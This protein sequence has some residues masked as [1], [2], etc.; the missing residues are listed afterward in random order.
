[1]KKTIKIYLFA[2]LSI[3]MSAI[4]CKDQ[5]LED[6]RSS[7]ITKQYFKTEGDAQAA[8]AGIY[9]YIKQ[10]FNKLGYD[11]VPY[12]MLELVT[13]IYDS[14]AQWQY[15]QDYI[16]LKY[17]SANPDFLVWWEQGYKGIE[18][19]NLSIANIPGIIMNEEIKNRLIGEARFLRA[20]YYY[21]LVNIFGDVPMKITPTSKPSEANIAKTSVKDIY[22]KV[23][24]PDLQYAEAQPLNPTTEGNGRVSVAAA[25]SLLAKVYLS[26]AGTLKQTEKYALAKTKA[27]EVISSQKHKLFQSEPNLTWFNK[28]NNPAFDNKEEHIWMANYAINNANSSLSVYFLPKE[29]KFVNA[30]QFGGFYPSTNFI[31]SYHTNDLRGMHNMG[32]FFNSINVKGNEY[33]FPWAIYKFFDPGILTTAPNSAKNFPMI[34]YADVLLTYAEAQNEADGAPDAIAYDALNSIRTRAGLTALSGMSKSDFTTEVW[35][36]RYWELCAEGKI[37]F[38]VVRTRKIFDPATSTF[39][40]VVG[41]VMPGGAVFKEENIKFPIPAREVQINPLLK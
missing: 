26:M 22:E 34:R 10:P 27:G 20:Y 11:D 24:V 30:L 1:M 18:A 36:E 33:N 9:D 31:K 8:V 35:K 38:D 28:L 4:S 37:W 23:I 16:N 7:I 41:H 25:K 5:L 17:D 39:S 21:T 32:F 19:A 12:S 6:A 29:V 3:S 15:G 14:K 13:G 40:D 2:A